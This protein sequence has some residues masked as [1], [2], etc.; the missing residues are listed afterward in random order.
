MDTNLQ[1]SKIEKINT[2]ETLQNL[3]SEIT[4]Q[5]RR[6]SSRSIKRKRFDDEIVE[7]GIPSTSQYSR[8]GRARTQSQSYIPSTQTTPVPT[9]SP[10][11]QNNFNNS[12]TV[13]NNSDTINSINLPNSLP[14]DIA[15]PTVNTMPVHQQF[16]SHSTVAASSVN[17]ITDK[18]NKSKPSGGTN[19]KKNKK[20]NRGPHQITTKDLGRWKPIDDLALIIGVQQT[21]DL[22]TVHRGTKFSC[23]FTLQELQQR[24]YSLLY[25]EP[26]SRIAISAMRNLHPELIENIQSKALFTVQEENILGTIKSTENPSVESFQDLL[27]KNPSIFFSARTPKSLYNHWH[28]MKQYYLLPDQT[29]K[30]LFN[31]DQP[32]S[33][34]DAEDMIEDSELTENKEEALEMEL[35]LADRRN[36]REIRH[37]ENELSRWTVLVDSLTGVGFTPEFDSQTLAVLRGRLVRYL[38][39]SKEITFGRSAKDFS[40]DVDLSLEGPAYKVSRKQGTIKL[41]SNGDF[42]ISNEG[43]R[44]IYIDGMPLLQGNKSRLSTN[45]VVE[46]AGLRFVFLVNYDLINAIRHESAKTTGPLN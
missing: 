8:I 21:N 31:D 5:K 7:F 9:A 18:R 10:S 6:S 27:D 40:V 19:S 1:P 2:N 26:I 43:K 13:L 25:E 45:C 34:S 14:V 28:L 12:A 46:I 22:R 15:S 37:L 41:R 36:K 3:N 24:W 38:M 16:N 39:R 11:T 17:I 35:A 29:T 32:I 20:G 42:F 30:P 33:F 4:D 23:K 44:P